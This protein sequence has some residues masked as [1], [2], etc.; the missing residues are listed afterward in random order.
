MLRDAAQ[1]LEDATVTGVR[2]RRV[3]EIDKMFWRAYDATWDA[4]RAAGNYAYHVLFAGASLN[5]E[6]TAD[7]AEGPK[8]ATEKYREAL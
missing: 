8:V 3:G 4:S 7:A 5:T 2:M 6:A 1:A